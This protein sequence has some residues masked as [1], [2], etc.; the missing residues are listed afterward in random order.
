LPLLFQE[1]ADEL[2]NLIRGCIEGKVAAVNDVDL[3]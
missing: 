3:G 2:G 1:H